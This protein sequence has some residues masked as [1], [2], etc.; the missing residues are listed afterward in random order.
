M[1]LSAFRKRMKTDHIEWTNHRAHRARDAF[2][3]LDENQILF[4]VSENRR[5]GANLLARCRLAVVAAIRERAVESV[6][7]FHMDSRPGRRLFQKSP[8][9]VMASR[10][11]ESTGKLAL[12]AADAAFDIDENRL[13]AFTKTQRSLLRKSDRAHQTLLRQGTRRRQTRGSVSDEQAAEKPLNAVMLIP[14]Q[15]EKNLGS[16]RFNELRGS[17]VAYG[18]SG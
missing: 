8:N 17:F 18:S 1:R 13:S 5:R 6:A 12:E 3:R 11:L 7:R 9:G 16:R 14:Q 2:P 15:R 10:M 4:V